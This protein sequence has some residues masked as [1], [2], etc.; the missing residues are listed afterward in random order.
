MAITATPVRNKDGCEWG[1]T[2][3][4]AGLAGIRHYHVNTDLEELAVF[5]DGLPRVGDAWGDADLA[6]LYCTRIGPAIRLGGKDLTGLG[7][8]G[9]CRVPVEYAS[10]TGSSFNI[11]SDGRKW[12]ELRLITGS[13][14]IKFPLRRW[15]VEHAAGVM[16][17]PPAYDSA[18]YSGP[19][20]PIEGGDG[21]SIVATGIEARVHRY[22]R[23]GVEY[24][25]NRSVQ[26]TTPRPHVNRDPII[27]PRINGFANE[28]TV[29]ERQALYVGA[30]PPS[31]DGLYVKITHVLQLAD[32]WRFIWQPKRREGDVIRT[33][34]H[35]DE[36]YDGADF[37][38]LW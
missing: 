33:L 38:N 5:A 2:I 15:R 32:D 35:F 28:W 37:S 6:S 1:V 36:T 11:P 17:N 16:P 12:T 18:E 19:I 34:T 14:T 4:D 25:F 13:K 27:L 8:G 30:E 24:D 21:C 31:V 9:W 7:D 3:T 20:D 29:G 23:L 22:Y 26:L 10:P